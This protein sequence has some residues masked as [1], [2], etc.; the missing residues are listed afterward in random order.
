VED[1]LRAAC[2]AFAPGCLVRHLLGA[3]RS[4]SSVRVLLAENAGHALELRFVGLPVVRAPSLS[5]PRR[6]GRRRAAPASPDTAGFYSHPDREY[7]PSNSLRSRPAPALSWPAW[8]MNASN[9]ASGRTRRRSAGPS[10][11]RP[12]AATCAGMHQPFSPFC[13]LSRAQRPRKASRSLDQ[14]PFRD[15]ATGVTGFAVAHFPFESSFRG[16]GRWQLRSVAHF[17]TTRQARVPP[18]APSR[19]RPRPTP[20]SVPSARPVLWNEPLSGAIE[21][22]ARIRLPQAVARHS[23]RKAASRQRTSPVPRLLLAREIRAGSQRGASA[24]Q[25]SF[26]S[27]LLR[28]WKRIG[29]EPVGR[30]RWNSRRGSRCQ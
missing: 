12:L 20:S 14:S 24:P 13:D 8:P 2:P 29:R 23:S 26:G 25:G 9:S 4:R 27:R 28:R 17:G 3:R 6:P 22:A 30:A 21:D 1:D 5:V 18:R 7:E 16:R 15:E 10:A 19:T 11:Y